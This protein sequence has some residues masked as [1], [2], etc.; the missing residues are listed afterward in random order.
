MTGT[1][2]LFGS[3]MSPYSIK[4]RSFFRYKNVPHEWIA[5]SPATENEYKKFARLPIVPTVATPEGEG[6]Q[7]STPIIEALEARYPTPSIHPDNELHFLSA[8]IEE[9]GDE[10]G[11]KLMFHFR[12]WDEIDQRASAQTLARLMQ[13]HG[14][15]SDIANLAKMILA[16]MTTRGHFVG[17]SKETAPLIEAYFDELIAILNSHL[18]TRPYLFGARPAF[19]DFGLA[20]QLYEC[21]VDPTCGSILRARSPHILDW[22]FR[23]LEPRN[24]GPFE[25]WAMLES[26]MRPLLDHIGRTFLPWSVANAK[27]LAAGEDS[28]TVTIAAKPY[29]Q[30]PQKYHAKSLAVLREKYRAASTNLQLSQILNAADCTRYLA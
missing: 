25:T 14:A 23:M 13:P 11:N 15:K 6:L 3:E 21:A 16:R 1:Y 8:L 10:W 12:W 7:D 24:D 9:F 26:T 29:T 30:S 2:K 4:V 19:A 18:A 27:A 20:A 22:T 28:F 5:R 17:S